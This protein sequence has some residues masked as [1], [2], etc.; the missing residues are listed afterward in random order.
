MGME[1]E[2]TFNVC[3]SAYLFPGKTNNVHTNQRLASLG[4]TNGALDNALSLEEMGAKNHYDKQ[5]SPY[6][7]K[8][9]AQTGCRVA[10]RHHTLTTGSSLGRLKV[11]LAMHSFS[12]ATFAT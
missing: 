12:F 11:P 3:G 1:R 7:G 8:E 9:D 10:R 6:H 4:V 2:G 5:W